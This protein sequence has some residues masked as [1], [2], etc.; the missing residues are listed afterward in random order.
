M[1]KR[2]RATM[3]TSAIVAIAFQLCFLIELHAPT[4]ADAI[5]WSLFSVSVAFFALFLYARA[6]LFSIRKMKRYQRPVGPPN[7]IVQR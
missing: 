2:L 7:P 5:L 1:R 4:P 3:W 6:R